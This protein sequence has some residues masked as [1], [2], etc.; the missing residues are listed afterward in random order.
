[1]AE[2]FGLASM[3]SP[4]FPASNNSTV[5]PRDVEIERFENN[6]VLLMFIHKLHY[7]GHEADR[8]AVNYGSG[9][10]LGPCLTI[11]HF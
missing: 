3:R 1:M 8:Q 4:K 7:T 11:T 10:D 6:V 9:R 5:A 2:N